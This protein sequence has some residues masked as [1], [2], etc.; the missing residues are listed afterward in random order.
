LSAYF[1]IRRLRY[2]SQSCAGRW[3]RKRIVDGPKRSNDRPRRVVEIDDRRAFTHEFGVEAEAE[4]I[5][6]SLSGGVDQARQDDVAR[7]AGS[8]SF[9]HNF[10][11][12][13]LRPKR[14]SDFR[15]YRFDGGEAKRSGGWACPRTR[16]NIGADASVRSASPPDQIPLSIN[17]LI[18]LALDDGRPGADRIDLGLLVG[19]DDRI[20]RSADRPHKR[21]RNPVP[22]H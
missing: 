10:M 21:Y 6:R 20:A 9:D 2:R 4:S 5:A 13:P 15:G 19:A 7:R 11:A 1:T 8:T 22:T 14:L 17:D 12:G 3:L 18:D 16:E